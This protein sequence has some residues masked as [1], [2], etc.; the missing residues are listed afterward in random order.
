MAADYTLLMQK[1][2]AGSTVKS[3][4][5]D[6]GFAVCDI[7]WSDE[8]T[9]EVA[10]REWPGMHGEDAYIP[11]A[12]LKLKAHDLE[13]EF[14][15]KGEVDT[16]YAKY[17]VLR[18]YLIGVEGDGAELRMYDPYWK[19]AIGSSYLKKISDLEPFRTEVDEGVGFKATFRVTDPVAEF[20]LLYV[21][22]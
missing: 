17:K 16:A 14:I 9:Q 2:K 3:S 19:R 6:F 5:E 22:D 12:G 10:T 21:G 4:L 7:P 13:V 18:K 8:E 1:T 11:P 20:V 15:Y